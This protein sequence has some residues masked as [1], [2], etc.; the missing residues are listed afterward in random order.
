MYRIICVEIPGDHSPLGN[1][2]KTLQKCGYQMECL[3]PQA[4]LQ[5]IQRKKPDAVLVDPTLAEGVQI[6]RELR[7]NP[8]TEY[9]PIIF[10]HPGA[11][12]PSSFTKNLEGVADAIL[13]N[14][15]EQELLAR[16]Q[17]AIRCN[18][19][20]QE[21][22]SLNRQLQERNLQ[23]EKELYIARQLQQSLL[24]PFLPDECGCND[25]QLSKC[26]YRSER[27]RIS[28]LYIPCDALGGDIYDV[29]QFSNGTI[30]VA[31][32]DVS[33]HG[34]PAGFITAI[35]KSAFYRITHTQSMP[36]DILYHINNEMADIVKTGDYVTAL[37]GL[38]QPDESDPERLTFSFSGAGHPYPLYYNASTRQLTRLKENGTPLVWFKNMEYAT[39]QI[40][41]SAGDKLLMFT[42][43][44]TELRNPQGELFGEEALERCFTE[45]VESGEANV[46]DALAQ[47]L[48]DFTEGHPLEDDLSMVYIEAGGG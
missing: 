22:N 35:F 37:Y 10:V 18:L 25:L 5:Q 45:L 23:V 38:L 3:P 43:G 17:S 34:V 16:L 31:I 44:V 15:G 20:L 28:G 1:V 13:A 48:S 29:I 46:L 2:C 41:L 8:E 26:H 9:M 14:I 12:P 39:A 33:G 27:L 42:D 21:A 6:G 30:G 24:P 11:Q 19:A 47:R 7:Q 32:A 40:Q 36:G 4:A